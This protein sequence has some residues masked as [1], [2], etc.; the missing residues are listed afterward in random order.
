MNNGFKKIMSNVH[1]FLNKICFGCVA[2]LL[3][4]K[5]NVK[6]IFVPKF[7]C[8][9]NPIEGFWCYLKQYVRKRNDQNFET[10][11]RLISEA[12]QSY[13]EISLRTFHLL[14]EKLKG[15]T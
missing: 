2:L 14:K 9:C 10:M 12:I 13:K 7:H 11:K 5:W 6:I 3:A 8:E 15:I 1:L 4:S